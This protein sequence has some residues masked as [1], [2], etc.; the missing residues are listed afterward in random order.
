MTDAPGSHLAQ[1]QELTADALV[2]LYEIS[3]KHN[4][5]V[6][7]FKDQNEVTWQGNT[8]ESMACR[9]TGD[10]RSSDEEESRP[11]LQVMNPFGVFNNAV[12]T[13]KID[14]AVVTRYRVRYYD[15]VNNN[16]I[17][18]KRMW[19]IGR[20]KELISDQA[21]TFELR[22]MTDGPNF[23]VPARQYIPP[24]FPTVSL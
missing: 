22:N 8:Y 4:N 6:Y 10:Q 11:T 14:Q 12:I 7:R 17:K 2:D 13:G 15:L 20:V 9:L 5:V 23:Q 3:L 24:D 18:E 19:Y 16:N 1:A 21:V